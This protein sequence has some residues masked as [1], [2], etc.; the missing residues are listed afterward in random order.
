[1]EVALRV[2]DPS[3]E[4]T[5]DVL[6]RAQEANTVADL[7]DVLVRAMEWPR[8]TFEGDPLAYAV[9]RLGTESP[10]DARMP[11]VSLNLKQGELLVLGPTR[12]G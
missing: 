8:T 10:L 4:A 12:G 5:R 7:I 3:G 2:Q 6:V 11:V 1:M 9:R